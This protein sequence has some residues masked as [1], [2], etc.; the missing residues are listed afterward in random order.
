MRVVVLTDD[1]VGPAMAGSGLRA[2]EIACSLRRAGH[3]VSVVAASGSEAPPGGGPELV[4]RPPW[5][6]ADVVVAPPWSLVPRA[7]VGRHR[8]VIDGATPLLAELA[9]M[10]D[11]PAIRRRR[12]TA[13]ARLPLVAARADAVLVAGRA[14][15]RWW[16]ELL[17]ASR[18]SVPVLQV[19]FG[20][21]ERP[22]PPDERDEIEQVPKRWAVVLWW[23]GV[24]PWLD[25]DTLLAARARLGRAPVSVVVPTAPRPGQSAVAFTA[26]DLDTAA[27]RHGLQAP[28]VV[29]LEHWVPYAQRHRLLNRTTLLAVLHNAGE[30]AELSFRTRA[31]D[32]LW[33]GVPLLLSEGGE[34]ARLAHAGGWGG[35][36]PVGAV[37]AAAAALELLLGA[38]EQLRCR[39][40]MASARDRWRWSRVTEPLVEALPQLP[41]VPRGRVTVAALRAAVALLK[42]RW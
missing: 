40:I 3:V 8:L 29:A 6:W 5:R 20:V 12:R 14:Q 39:E 18:S 27:S 34:V 10:P 31:L 35:V 1:L 32:G 38:R 19:P 30:E 36:V 21:P 33:A 24:W 13:A 41:A 16:R 22:P 26:A 15:E 23:G 17:G 28:E 42:G 4:P 11:S 2:W 9:A 7:C 37:N 25:L